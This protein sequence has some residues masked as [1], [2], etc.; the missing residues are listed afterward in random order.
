M[1]YLCHSNPIVLFHMDL[2]TCYPSVFFSTGCKYDFPFVN[3]RMTSLACFRPTLSAENGRSDTNSNIKIAQECRSPQV[4]QVKYAREQGKNF[5]WILLVLYAMFVKLFTTQL[6]KLVSKRLCINSV[7]DDLTLIRHDYVY[8]SPSRLKAETQRFL[9]SVVVSSN[10]S[11]WFFLQMM[12]LNDAK[13]HIYIS[14]SWFWL[15]LRD[16][17][18]AGSNRCQAAGHMDENQ[19]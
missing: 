9:L 13:N 19:E 14:S 15:C 3:A 18:M 8:W 5:G 4:W 11:P 7:F 12:D 6:N 17:N 16:T 2:N 10:S 1:V